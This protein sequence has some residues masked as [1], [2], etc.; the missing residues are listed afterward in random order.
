MIWG[1][2]VTSAMC[3]YLNSFYTGRL[4]A[5]GLREQVPDLFSYFGAAA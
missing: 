3:Y 4:I 1:Q 5:Y 2:I